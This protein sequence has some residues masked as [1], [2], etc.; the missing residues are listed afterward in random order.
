MP[1]HSVERQSSLEGKGMKNLLCFRCL[2]GE[3]MIAYNHY[4]KF[5]P[6]L[7]NDKK[8]EGSFSNVVTVQESSNISLDEKLQYEL[9]FFNNQGRDL[10]L[11][12]DREF[13]RTQKGQ[14]WAFE[15]KSVV[16]FF[17]HSD[18]LGLE[19]IKYD[20]FT[21]ELLEYWCLHIVLPIFF[22]IEETFDFLHAGAVEVDGKPILFVA[23]SFG[24]KSTM[25]DFFMKQGHTMLSDDKVATYEKEGHFLVVPSHPHHRPHRGME[26][27]GFFIENVSKDPKPIH[28]MYELEK[29][30]ENSEVSIVEVKGTEKFKSLRY[31]SEINLFFMKPKRFAYLMQLAQVVPVYRVSVPW[32]LERLDE[33]YYKIVH[34]SKNL[35]PGNVL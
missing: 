9:T 28:A 7:K 3:R 11:Y 8:V 17:W 31:A 35:N 6:E 19:Y 20:N 1:G 33:V 25:T 10:I 18:T 22:T 21:E 13:V 29:A 24:G 34:H 15:V 12:T 32:D 23:E 14:I 2:S 4:I 26:D 27:L 16:K 5:I 30:D